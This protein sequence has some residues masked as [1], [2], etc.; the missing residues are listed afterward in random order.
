MHAR[1]PWLAAAGIVLIVDMGFAMIAKREWREERF[2][3]HS[4][5]LGEL[6][7]WVAGLW[8]A[9]GLASEFIAR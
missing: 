4:G 1:H 7:T 6:D 3:L 9:L 5:T 8:D 2:F